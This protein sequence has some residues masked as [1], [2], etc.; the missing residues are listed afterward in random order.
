LR[1]SEEQ[2]RGSYLCRWEEASTCWKKCVEIGSSGEFVGAFV[3]RN[4][5]THPGLRPP[6]RRR[7]MKQGAINNPLLW[8]GAGTA[9]WV[10][11]SQPLCKLD[12]RGDEWGS[13]QTLEKNVPNIGKGTGK[14]PRFGR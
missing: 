9:G 14:V 3:Y 11:V 1:K 13:F 5:L 8:R 4:L 12:K 7:G 6:L 2:P 10:P